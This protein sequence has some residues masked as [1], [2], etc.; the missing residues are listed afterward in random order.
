VLSGYRDL[1]PWPAP[2]AGLVL[3]AALAIRR[4][5]RRR[6]LRTPED[7]RALGPPVLARLRPDALAGFGPELRLLASKLVVL[8]GGRIP[9]TLLVTLL[10]DSGAPAERLAASLAAGAGLEVRVER[11]D[12]RRSAGADAWIAL[13]TLGTMESEIAGQRLSALAPAGR[14]P[15]GLVLLEGEPADPTAPSPLAS[16]AA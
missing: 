6:R 9:R 5:A 1:V 10:D 16:A 7:A 12:E 15:D 8:G 13:L 3:G 2:L 14:E 11:W 4:G